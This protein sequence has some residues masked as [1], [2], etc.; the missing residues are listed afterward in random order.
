MTR[1]LRTPAYQHHKATGQ[2]CVKLNGKFHYLGKYDSAE[3]K[4][5]YDD[6]MSRWLAKGRQLPP[7]DDAAPAASR[8]PEPDSLAVNDLIY[9]YVNRCAEYYRKAG[10]PTSEAAVIK[11]ALQHLK[12]THGKTLVRNFG[13]RALKE[14]REAMIRSERITPHGIKQRLC[15]HVVNS[16]VARIKGMFKWGL[17]E[18][19]VP[20]DV[21]VKLTSVKALAEGRTAARETEPVRPVPDAHVEAIREHVGR[22]VWALVELLALTGARAGEIVIMRGCDLDVTG[23][24][25]FYR[26]GRHKNQHR[27]QPRVI[28]LGPRAQTIIKEFLKPDL[29]AYIFSPADAVAEHHAE[30]RRSRKTKVQPS[31]QD[32]SKP[33]SQV[34]PGDHYTTDSLR[35]A[36]ARGCDRAFPPPEPLSKHEDETEAEW[37]ARLTDEQKAAFAAWQK[38]HRWTPH[39]V[40]HAVATKLR[41]Q[42]GIE[43][44]RARLG[45]SKIDTTEIYAEQ[46][47][48]K[49]RQVVE[50]TG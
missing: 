47:R 8:A 5:A 43:V 37:Q 29:T 6:L 50:A 32:R 2:G 45:H 18:E 24:I 21:Y 23:D 27:G 35:R 17:E 14:V 34:A 20:A 36:I 15:R 30:E 10:H 46:D 4:A 22:H 16:Y 42:Y 12:A 38:E 28:D 33:E 39:Q 48:E 49:L 13:P 19:L 44:S 40:R 25:W 11:S 41:K 31:Q 9:R 3:S 7:D 26:P 1:H